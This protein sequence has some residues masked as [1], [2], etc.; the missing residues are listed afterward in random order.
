MILSQVYTISMHPDSNMRQM[1]ES[2]RAA[3][4]TLNEEFEF[5][6]STVLGR[7]CM[8]TVVHNGDWA[9]VRTVS[10][11]PKGMD[12]PK[13]EMPLLLY[14]TDNT[15]SYNDLPPW[16]QKKLAK[17]QAAADTAAMAQGKQQEMGDEEAPF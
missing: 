8:V 16:I 14:D 9:N 12:V 6:I 3:T 15:E 5:D 11:L 1:L 10:P 13:A 4:F 2:W 7:A 17:E